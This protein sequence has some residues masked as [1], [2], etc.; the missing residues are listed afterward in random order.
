[1][2]TIGL[3]FAVS[4]AT[5][6]V[7]FETVDWTGDEP[8]ASLCGLMRGWTLGI[9]CEAKPLRSSPLLGGRQ[10]SGLDTKAPLLSPSIAEEK[11]LHPVSTI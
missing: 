11:Q 10:T 6:L 2:I 1:M 8:G 7:V 9:I 4:C 5:I 3:G